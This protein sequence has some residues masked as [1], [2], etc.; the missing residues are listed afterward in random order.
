MKTEWADQVSIE[1]GRILFFVNINYGTKTGT[2]FL[3]QINK[4]VKLLSENPYLGK[5]E[6]LLDNRKQ[7]FRSLVVNRLNKIIYYI[8]NDTLYIAD[9]WDTRK[10]PENLANRIKK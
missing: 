5:I 10:N 4:N 3:K 7:G 9:I 6:T 2:K 1:L 8:E